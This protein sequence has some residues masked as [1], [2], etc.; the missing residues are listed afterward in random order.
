M[1]LLKFFARPRQKKNEAVPL[2]PMNLASPA[3]ELTDGRRIGTGRRARRPTTIISFGAELFKSFHSQDTTG[4]IKAQSLGVRIAWIS[5][6]DS[7][8][9]RSRAKSLNVVE[10][11]FSQDKKKNVED[12]CLRLGIPVSSACFIGDD[13]L[14]IPAMQV[15][16]LPI[17]VANAVDEVKKIAAYVTFRTGGDGAVRKAIDYTL[18]HHQ[19]AYESLLSQAQHRSRPSIS[20]NLSMGDLLSLRT[21][22]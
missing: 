20:Q 10:T 16:G 18:R 15:V 13:D 17:A 21:G 2:S 9:T 19:Q 5:A 12:V 6:K 14:D 1:A 11:H 22:R 4:I 7:A 8:I 3:N